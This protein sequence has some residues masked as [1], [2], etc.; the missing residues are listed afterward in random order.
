MTANTRFTAAHGRRELIACIRSVR[1]MLAR[2]I[3]ASMIGMLCV[4]RVALAEP[5]PLTP[6]DFAGRWV[7][8]GKKL[9][10][11]IT[12]CGADWCGIV[13]ENESCGLAAL[14]ASDP[15]PS[16]DVLQSVGH[17]ELLG[18][19]RLAARTEPYGV[20]VTLSR[21]DAGT[22]VIFVAGHSGGTFAAYRR[23]YDYRDQMVRAGDAKCR[24]DPKQS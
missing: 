11:D 15:S 24:F 8:E 6:D 16:A 1:A 12:R 22:P 23:T 3:V 13:V 2:P 10:L 5:A 20:A 4:A 7:S 19:L 17:P 14:R 9:T 18:Q 21:S